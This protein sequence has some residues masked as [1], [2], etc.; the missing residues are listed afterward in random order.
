MT[1]G[2]RLAGL[3]AGLSMAA[4][5]ST[6]GWCGSADGLPSFAQVQE[7]MVALFAETPFAWTNVETKAGP[8]SVDLFP[9]GRDRQAWA[10]LVQ[11]V[12]NSKPGLTIPGP[13]GIVL[14][15]GRNMGDGSFE[16]RPVFY[17][18]G[19]L[20]CSDP[21]LGG[22]VRTLE[23]GPEFE[24]G[25]RMLERNANIRLKWPT[26]PV[27]ES[28]VAARAARV[29]RSRAV[30]I[31]SRFS[32]QA[33][34][35]LG[36]RPQAVFRVA[37]WPFGPRWEVR[38]GELVSVSVEANDGSVIEV[39][40]RSAQAA[41]SALGM[42]A[43]LSEKAAKT[44]AERLLELMEVPRKE[45]VFEGTRLTGGEGVGESWSVQ[46]ARVADGIRY[47]ED[48]CHVVVDGRTG[49]IIYAVRRFWSA[50]PK[51]L[52]VKV[53]KEQLPGILKRIAARVQPSGGIAVSGEPELLIVQPNNYY[54][55]PRKAKQSRYLGAT[56]VAWEV[57]AADTEGKGHRR[58]YRIWIDV[59][60]GELL[61]GYGCM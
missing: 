51:S 48:G 5:L 7:R 55:K 35:P 42:K 18:D 4:A 37:K 27:D 22:N 33:G 31:A 3:I 32:D 56:R 60:T 34:I 50:P 26:L 53:G 38:R 61:G 44:P 12:R 46:W 58:E 28:K 14:E 47:N 25:L 39:S 9:E 41:N 36:D 16:N 30:G 24:R 17:K 15:C 19:M 45:L 49:E 23:V 10:L 20:S 8:K 52:A 6:Q 2:M 29:S 59:V 13:T 57:R 43:T 21:Y 1:K 11:G 54:P 40:N